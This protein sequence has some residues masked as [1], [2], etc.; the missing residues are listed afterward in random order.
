M[1]TDRLDDFSISDLPQQVLNNLLAWRDS[2]SRGA[3]EVGDLTLEAYELARA[4]GKRISVLQVDRQV[5]QVVGVA[6]RT[7]RYYR[8][9]AAFYNGF[10]REKYEVL[11]FSHFVFAMGFKGDE[12]DGK[13]TWEMILEKA[14]DYMGEHGVP[15]SVD[16]LGKLYHKEIASQRDNYQQEAF[17]ENPLPSEFDE[18]ENTLLGDDQTPMLERVGHLAGAARSTVSNMVQI[19]QAVSQLEHA[20]GLPPEMA[21]V[22]SQALTVNRQV[23]TVLEE[24]EKAARAVPVEN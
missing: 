7:I 20:L 10:T 22:I 14:L 1:D 16:A 3:W 13:P 23:I 18:V 19:L 9:A 12:A 11:P 6:E 4:N 2:F 21:Q 17:P 8:T 15:P 24:Y 5:A